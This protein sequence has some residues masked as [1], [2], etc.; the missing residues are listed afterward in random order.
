MLGTRYWYKMLVRNAGYVILVRD[1]GTGYWY[2]ILVRDA[3][4]GCWY[5]ILVRDTGTGYW[6]LEIGT[7][8]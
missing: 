3:G 4:T 7:G 6:V 5:G 8:Y 2:G 1:A